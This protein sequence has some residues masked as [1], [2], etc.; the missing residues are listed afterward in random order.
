MNKSWFLVLV[1]VFPVYSSSKGLVVYTKGKSY[2]TRDG[3]KKE[4]QIRT[5]IEEK[6]IITTEKESSLHVQL[7]NGVMIRIGANTKIEFEKILKAIQQYEYKLVLRQGE[8]LTKI[9][10]QKEKRI[11]FDVQA[12]TAIASVRGTEFLMEADNNKTL[13]AVN[14]G[15]L[16]V[17][18][19][20]QKERV[21]LNS[22]EKIIATYEAFEKSLLEDYEKKKFELLQEFEKT[23][24]KNLEI[25][26]QQL[27]SN[28]KIIEEQKKKLKN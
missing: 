17:M 20:N 24:Q 25:L 16:M 11:Q 12:P 22:G 13:I 19:I 9:D 6:D 2:L 1:I 15:S 14:D 3:Q 21:I 4:I 10:K 18:D 26:I 28:Q 7:A 5:L 8:V 23:R 27:E